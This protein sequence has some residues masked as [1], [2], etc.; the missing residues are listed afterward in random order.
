[1]KGEAMNQYIEKMKSLI[2]VKNVHI[3]EVDSHNVQIFWDLNGM[4]DP[5]VYFEIMCNNGFFTIYRVSRGQGIE[6]VSFENEK[7][8][9]LFLGLKVNMSFE[10]MTNPKPKEIDDF[11][12]AKEEEKKQI[13]KI[14][15][16]YINNKFFSIF[17]N[18]NNSIC[19]LK[20]GRYIVCFIDSKGNINVISDDND[21]F[22]MGLEVMCNYAWSL[23]WIE[24][25]VK[26][27]DIDI[28]S[29]EFLIAVKKLLDVQ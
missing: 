3:H 14:I 12:D 28:D 7:Y 1:M 16:K 27:W 9:Y 15:S 13:E 25:L 18:Q 17:Q 24:K 23:Q 8:A 11:F 2:I 5:E 22:A 20:E 10:D 4:I 29:Q 26:S 19:L 6:V 21:E